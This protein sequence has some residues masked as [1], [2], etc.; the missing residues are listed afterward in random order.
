[1][2][3]VD[4][5]QSYLP[6]SKMPSMVSKPLRFFLVGTIGTFVQTGFFLLLML[7][8]SQPEKNSLL[9]Y[10]AFIGGFILEMI[11]NYFCMSFYTFGAMP[12]KKNGWGFVLARSINLIMQ[13]VV[14]PLMILW[15]P[16]VSDAIISP[17][18]IF[19]AGVVNFLIQLLFF[20][21]KDES[22]NSKS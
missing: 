7:C 18:V 10:V 21:K 16:T 19:I 13:L 3:F 2:S 5:F 4:K 9:Y 12:N 6:S 1:M 8:L 20:K 17:I 14:L 22:A 11:P 15:L